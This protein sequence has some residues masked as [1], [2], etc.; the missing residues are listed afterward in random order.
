[1]RLLMIGIVLVIVRSYFVSN[2]FWLLGSIRM[3]QDT[4]SGGVHSTF[5]STFFEVRPLPLVVLLFRL[6]GDT[7]L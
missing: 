1:M 5:L 4:S 2:A 6:G 3:S 7:R